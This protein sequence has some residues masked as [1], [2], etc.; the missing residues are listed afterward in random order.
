MATIGK[1]DVE[2]KVQSTA[3][4]FWN[5]IMNSATIFPKVCSGL[6]KNVEVLEGDGQS[7]G[8]VRVIHFAEGS[9]IKKPMKEKIEEVDEPNMKV[10]YSV[11]DGDVMQFYK[12]FKAIIEVIP[13]GEGSLVKCCYEYEKASDEVPHPSMV[14]DLVAKNLQAVDAYLL[15]A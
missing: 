7:V 10:V 15:N 12:T 13:E 1:L 4:K 14:G 3:D 2:V 5:S 9:P 6:Y 8:T 11:M